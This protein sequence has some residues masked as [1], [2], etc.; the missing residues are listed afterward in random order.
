MAEVCISIGSNIDKEKNIPAAIAQLEKNFSTLKLSSVYESKS[1]GF[2][3]NDFHNLVVFFKSENSPEEII[4]ILRN[5]EK[6]LGRVRKENKFSDRTIDLDI[7]LYDDLTQ[8]NQNYSIPS[9]EITEYAFVLLP[10]AEIAGEKIHPELLVPISE[11][12]E[13]FKALNKKQL[14]NIN[15]IQS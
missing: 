13:E 3:G 5:I 8:K 9:E 12:W 2:D 15:K 14:E 4:E 1:A 6:S 10:L 11:I 7:L